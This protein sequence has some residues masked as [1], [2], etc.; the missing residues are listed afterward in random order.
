MNVGP[1]DGVRLGPS[2]GVIMDEETPD[3]SVGPVDATQLGISDGFKLGRDDGCP[4]GGSVVGANVSVKVGRPVGAEKGAIVENIGIEDGTMV[5]KLAMCGGV[6][7]L[8][9]HHQYSCS[10]RAR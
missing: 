5:F 10:R 9:H 2:D 6:E 4:E 8:P 3:V 1:Y 7:N